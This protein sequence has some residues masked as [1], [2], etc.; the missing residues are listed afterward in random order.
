MEQNDRVS[1]SVTLGENR[2]ARAE[3]KQLLDETRVSTQEQQSVIKEEKKR[4]ESQE[5]KDS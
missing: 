3:R 1:E 5:K 2:M 4:S